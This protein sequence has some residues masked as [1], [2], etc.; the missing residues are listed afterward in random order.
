MPGYAYPVGATE[1][2]VSKSSTAALTTTSVADIFTATAKT[3]INSL[4]ISNSN[5]GILPVSIYLNPVEAGAPTSDIVKNFRVHKRR[6]AVQ[7]LVS[8]DPR[9]TADMLG[10]GLVPTEIILNVGDKL[11]ASSRVANVI[12]F[13]ITYSEGVK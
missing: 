3:R 5:G 8:A 9:V 12:T 6:Y 11:Q 10:D 1:N 4:L 7:S 13:T 2:Y